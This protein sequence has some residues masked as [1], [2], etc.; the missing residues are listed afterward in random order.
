VKFSETDLADVR[1]IDIEPHGDERGFFARTLCRDEFVSNGLLPDY[2]QI[3]TSYSRYKGTLR[4]LHYQRAPH[5]EAKLVRC[6]R[7]AVWDLIVDLRRDSPTYL[8]HQGVELTAEN[9]RQIYVP[10][11]FAHSYVTLVD[12]SEVIYP[13]SASYTPQAEGGVRYDDPLL[14]IEWPV[15]I[16]TVSEKDMNWPLLD[17]NSPPF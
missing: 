9:R 3:N 7:G 11:G 8:R 10:P 12:D 4:G 5:T 6:V 14:A 13:V 1:V 2:V 16:T 15:E 17:R